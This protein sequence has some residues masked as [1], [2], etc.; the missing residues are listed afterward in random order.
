MR[1]L[2]VPRRDD[3]AGGNDATGRSPCAGFGSRALACGLRRGG[4][5]CGDD[6][7][8]QTPDARLVD[9][10]IELDAA[11]V[12]AGEL[13]VKAKNAGTTSHEVVFIRSDLPED[14]LP[15]D[16]NKVDE[17]KVDVVD[18]I[19]QF[20]AGKSEKEKKPITLEPG[21]YV[22]SCNIATHYGLGMHAV[23]DVK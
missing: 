9:F 11:Q 3:A 21:R 22:L 4:V 19:E 20:E 13:T 6:D 7:S 17:E 23:L 14:G 2:D 12:A 10:A 18:E 1:A 16:G 15:M 8:G 5:A